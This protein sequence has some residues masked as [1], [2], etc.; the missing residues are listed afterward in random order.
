MKEVTVR[1]P[2]KDYPFFIELVKHLGFVKLKKVDNELIK[3]QVQRNIQESVAQVN[4]I[5]S[6]KLKG[7]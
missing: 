6:G 1:I 7:H 3:E 4:Q 2:E 5:K